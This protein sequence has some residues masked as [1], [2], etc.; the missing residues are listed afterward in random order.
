MPM[1]YFHLTEDGR[2]SPDL[3]GSPFAS[4]EL[5]YLA[6]HRAIRDMWWEMVRRGKDPRGCS[7]EIHD[8]AATC[9]A[10]VPFVEAME[11]TMPSV[12]RS[13]ADD[14]HAQGA[15]GKDRSDSA[16][17]RTGARGW[18]QRVSAAHR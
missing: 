13:P 7:F 11:E 14:P 17:P 8:A 16:S 15:V 2:R 1:F 18:R 5:A 9:L 6:T 3:E 4:F 10:V 12:L